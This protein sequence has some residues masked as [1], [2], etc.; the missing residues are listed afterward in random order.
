MEREMEDY[1][2]RCPCYYSWRAKLFSKVQQVLHDDKIID[3]QVYQITSNLRSYSKGQLKIR[4]DIQV[5]QLFYMQSIIGMDHFFCGHISIHLNQFAT[6][7]FYSDK[8]DL[9]KQLITTLF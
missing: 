2:F 8:A 3:Q 5:K 7:C 1:I 9:T 4:G 6:R